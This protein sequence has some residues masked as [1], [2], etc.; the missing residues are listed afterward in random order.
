MFHNLRV[1][2]VLS[3]FLSAGGCRYTPEK[4]PAVPKPA[5][6]RVQLLDLDAQAIDPFDL[7]QNEAAKGSVFLF[8]KTD[9]PIS[10]R[11]APEVGRL[12][13]EFSNEKQVTAQ[14]PPTFLFHTTEDQAV[15]PENS[16][17]F[18]LALRRAG[19]PTEMHI[20]ERGR[21]GVG[22]A[23]NDPVLSSWPAR[24]AAWMKQRGLLAKK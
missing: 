12:V 24:C 9:C 17:L 1:L 2:F 10:N 18:Y 4:N 22:L 15:P 19:V 14:T 11:Y 16:V 5:A 21:H 7:P 6:P 20:Y 8:T 23:R 3:L 13:E